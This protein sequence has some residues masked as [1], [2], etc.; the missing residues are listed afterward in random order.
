M[1]NRMHEKDII[2]RAMEKAGYKAATWVVIFAPVA[3]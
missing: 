3:A 1:M 2:L